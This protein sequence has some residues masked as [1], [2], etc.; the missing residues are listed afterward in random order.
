MREGLTAAAD[1]L[2]RRLLE[3][4]LEGGRGIIEEEMNRLARDYYG[5]RGWNAEGVPQDMG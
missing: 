4:T 2:P 3:E 5:L 1:R